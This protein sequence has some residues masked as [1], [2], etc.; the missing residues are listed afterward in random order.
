MAGKAAQTTGIRQESS[1]YPRKEDSEQVAQMN[2]SEKIRYY[3]GDNEYVLH[4]RF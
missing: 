3:N 1:I 2:S 4:Y